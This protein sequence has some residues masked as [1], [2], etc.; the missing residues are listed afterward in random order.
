MRPATTKRPATLTQS[1]PN[2][3]ALATAFVLLSILPAVCHGQDQPKTK[4]TV[5]F[6][7]DFGVVDDSVALCKG[8]MYSV[9]P[10]LRI[11]DLTHQVTTFSILDGA[12][13]LEGASPY[14]PAGTVFVVV[15]DPGVGSARKA[16]M[17]KSKRGQYFVLPDNGLMTL[18]QDR[19]GLEAAR[20]ITNPNWMIGAGISSTFHGRDIFSPAGAHVARPNPGCTCGASAGATPECEQS[21]SGDDVGRDLVFDEG[22]AVA[23]LQLAFLQPLQ[24]QQVRRRRL[25]QRVDRCVEIAV[26]LLQPGEFVFELALI[27]VGHGVR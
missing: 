20:E 12:R 1:W 14:F 17:V 2:S 10:D 3:F 25:M 8:V 7:T 5:V 27:F 9:A 11:V 18:I 16:V 19:D 4:P 13:Y 24:P 22:D 23:Q 26:L 6:M 21:R 15:I